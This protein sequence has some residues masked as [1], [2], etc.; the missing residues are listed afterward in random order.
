MSQTRTGSLV[1]S[2]ANVAIGYLVAVA[3]NLAFLPAFGYPVTTGDAF[4]IGLVFTAISLAR[5]YLLR[6]LFE[7]LRWWRAE[8]SRYAAPE[9]GS[10]CDGER[11]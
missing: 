7:R 2:L 5:S 10:L 11:P 9:P 1:E 8:P 4:G 3:A 6:R